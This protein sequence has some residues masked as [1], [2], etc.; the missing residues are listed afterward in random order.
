[1]KTEIRF[2]GKT[3][4][5]LAELVGREEADPAVV[6]W[7]LYVERGPRK[8]VRIRDGLISEG[9]TIHTGP[10]E[11]YRGYL[12]LHDGPNYSA[13]EEE[14]RQGVATLA[15]HNVVATPARLLPP[16]ERIKIVFRE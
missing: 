5:E 12:F 16:A 3:R 15:T 1:M 13:A 11:P 10:K 2:S 8:K 6:S 7:A 4:D 9:R 14:I